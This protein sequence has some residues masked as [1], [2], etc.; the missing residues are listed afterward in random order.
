MKDYEH[1]RHS[2]SRAITI[3]YLGRATSLPVDW[4]RFWSSGNNNKTKWPQ[5]L[6]EQLVDMPLCYCSAELVVS[7]VGGESPQHCQCAHNTTVAHLSGRRDERLVPHVRMDQLEL[8][9]C[10]Q[11]RM[12]F[13]L[14]LFFWKMLHP[15]LCRIKGTIHGIF[16]WT[17]FVII[18]LSYVRFFLRHMHWWDAT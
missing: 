13:V 10:H 8:C 11:T 1:G 15:P 2:Q 9:Y 16:L 3:S 6:G 12:C 18:P 5:L 17:Y 7:G 14:G 4:S